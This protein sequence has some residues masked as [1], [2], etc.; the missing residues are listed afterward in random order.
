MR[1][2]LFS[3]SMAFGAL[4]VLSCVSF[5][6]ND[7]GNA[8]YDGNF[9][10]YAGSN[11]VPSTNLA[12]GGGNALTGLAL[13]QTTLQQVS[14]ATK[15]GESQANEPALDASQSAATADSG[16]TLSN[17]SGGGA[18]PQSLAEQS[19]GS[20]GTGSLGLGGVNSTGRSGG[21]SSTSGAGSQGGGLGS[22]GDTR[23][24]A[25][26]GAGLSG[27]N[28]ERSLSS[29]SDSQGSYAG[30]SGSSS[31]GKSLNPFSSLFGGEE[32]GGQKS[33]SSTTEF[34]RDPASLSGRDHASRNG[35][36]PMSSQD[37]ANYFT[38]L[39]TGDSLFKTVERRYVW[40]AK[41]WAVSDAQEIRRSVNR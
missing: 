8:G 31:S 27:A 13:G 38:L 5:S 2:S 9:N 36:D 6:C 18:S 25:L 34:G 10:P 28:G 16:G 40:K 14:A 20:S 32:N 35:S 33:G 23:T 26:G 39:N 4:A 19:T 24:T 29:A 3:R 12:D 22:L 1:T 7:S 21:S 17:S 41:Q 30:G 15:A 37:P 11:G